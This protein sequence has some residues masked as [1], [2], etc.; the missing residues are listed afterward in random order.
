MT[1]VK[2]DLNR[3]KITGRFINNNYQR[4]TNQSLRFERNFRN[5]VISCM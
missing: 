3:D 1:Y 5:T 2:E 4:Q